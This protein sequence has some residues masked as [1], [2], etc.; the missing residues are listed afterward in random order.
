MPRT[1][2]KRP[3]KAGKLFL[4]DGKRDAQGTLLKCER[5]PVNDDCDN[6]QYKARGLTYFYCADN[7]RERRRDE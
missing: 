4:A 3:K 7:P 2:W 5:C 6:K 1:N